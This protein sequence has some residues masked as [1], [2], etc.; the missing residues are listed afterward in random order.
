MKDGSAVRTILKEDLD[1]FSSQITIFIDELKIKNEV[2]YKSNNLICKSLTKNLIEIAES[3]LISKAKRIRP[4]FCYWLLRCF[5]NNQEHY[6]SNLLKATQIA[7]AIEILH[8]ASLIID[9]IED[10]SQERRQ[11]NA[12]HIQYGMPNALNAGSWMYFLALT[13]FPNELQPLASEA[14]LDC[15]MGQ[16]IDLN[17]CESEFLNE[18]FFSNPKKRWE[19]YEKCVEL[20]TTRLILLSAQC[21]KILLE[22]K[23]LDFEFIKNIVLKYGI[24]Y[25]LFDDIKNMFPEFSGS[26]LNEDL[27]SGFRSAV[28]IEYLDL[29]PEE[30]KIRIFE[31]FNKGNFYQYII[32]DNNSITAVKKCFLKAESLLNETSK[33]I[34][35][36]LGLDNLHCLTILEIFQA[37]FSEIRKNIALKIKENSFSLNQ[38]FADYGN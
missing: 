19:Y 38:G 34:E 24:I 31:I 7:V 36:Y 25:Q 12:L 33:Y 10:G 6:K 17:S 35:D 5:S 4:L 15:H 18:F 29:I 37:P 14:L 16:A 30:E 22:I 11:E 9:D 8:N 21:F 23:N 26:K 1:F 13:H 3:A 28:S 2:E 27:K 20:K 32:Q